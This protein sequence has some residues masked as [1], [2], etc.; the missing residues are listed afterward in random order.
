M[1]K[2]LGLGNVWLLERSEWGKGNIRPAQSLITASWKLTRLC[3]P[4]KEGAACPGEKGKR[5]GG[6][7][8]EQ[9]MFRFHLTPS[10]LNSALHLLKRTRNP[11]PPGR[12]I[13]PLV[14]KVWKMGACPAGIFMNSEWQLKLYSLSHYFM[15]VYTSPTICIHKETCFPKVGSGRDPP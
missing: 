7:G 9:R 4:R 3:S 14:I 11:A 5:G 12:T 2:A 8:G 6:G 13:F 10:W 15:D 1:Q